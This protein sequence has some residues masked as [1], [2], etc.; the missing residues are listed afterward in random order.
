MKLAILGTGF[1][2]TDALTAISEVEGIEKNAIYSR[3]GSEDRGREFAEKFGIKKLYNDYQEI[4]ASD[5]I[6]TVYV[7]LINSVHYSYAKEALLAGKNAIVEKPFTPSYAEA[8][9]LLDIAKKKGVYVFDAVT[10]RHSAVFEKMKE[11]LDQIGDIRAVQGNYSQYSSRYDKYKNGEVLPAF[12]P[13]AYGGA[14]HDLG[15]YNL[16]IAVALLGKPESVRYD[17]N[18]GFNDVDLSGLLLMK[19]PTF[20]ASLMAAKDSASPSFFTVQGEKGWMRIPGQPNEIKA[21]DYNIGDGDVHFAPEPMKNRM[22]QEFMDFARIADGG[23]REEM[24]REMQDT[25]A[26]IKTMEMARES[27]GIAYGG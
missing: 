19:Y 1:I 25:L 9:E 8:K 18:K 15:I 23:D 26:V 14:L 24:E 22:V 17:A 2:I 27:S 20:Q 3:P 21:L 11:L 6:D 7:G 10:P 13:K 16:N 12:D 4:L 5:D